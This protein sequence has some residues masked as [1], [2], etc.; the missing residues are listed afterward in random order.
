[1]GATLDQFDTIDFSDNDLR[2]LDGFPYLARLK[3]LLL[4]N[5][6]IVRIGDTLKD[7][8]PNLE[9]VILT[10]NNIQE[11]G[12]LEA[13]AHLPNLQ[14]LC[15]LMNP[16]STKPHYREYIAFKFPNLRLLDFR[17]IKQKD[18]KVAQ[19]LFKSKK[20]KEL[21][22]E[23]TKRAK[24]FVP[25][26][27][28]ESNS[29]KERVPGAT[30]ADMQAIREA[31]KNATSLQE[32]ERLTRMLQA[33]QI[34]NGSNLNSHSLNGNGNN[35]YGMSEE[36]E[37]EEEEPEREQEQEQQ[38]QQQ[39]QPE[40]QA[41]Q[42]VE[43]EEEEQEQDEQVVEPQQHQHQREVE[44]EEVIQDQ[45]QQEEIQEVEEPQE[46]ESSE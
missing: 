13:L 20:G 36:M 3:C 7:T 45:H 2:K 31:I 22:K 38:P 15:L 14:T 27:G 1:M 34:P 5:N 44:E 21:H 24:T 26:A 35:G 19:D 32:V 16:V 4:N 30:P 25:G 39:Q 8:L 11:L 28:L 12:D 43:E 9:S 33:G 6:R 42:E 29:S 40:E 17:K 23:I 10:G 46:E 41:R 37:Q 18:R